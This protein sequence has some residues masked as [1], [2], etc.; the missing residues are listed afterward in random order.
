MSSLQ[1]L[2]VLVE[3]GG[4][5][6]E[7][8]SEDNSIQYE[9]IGTIP[10]SHANDVVENNEVAVENERSNV[11]NNEVVVDSNVED[12]EVVIDSNVEDNKVVIQDERDNVKN[13]EVMVVGTISYPTNPSGETSDKKEKTIVYERR[14]FK[15]QGEQI[16]QSQ[17]QQTPPVPNLPS[18]PSPSSSITPTGNVSPNL[19]HIELPLAQRREPM[20]VG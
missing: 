5:N 17:P 9:I 2:R 13:N 14:R 3:G 4:H 19:D 11:E 10:S 18:D 15:N 6:Y 16:E 12:N 8:S 7:H 20:I 1:S